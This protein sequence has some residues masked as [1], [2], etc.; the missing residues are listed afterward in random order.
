MH[1]YEFYDETIPLYF[2]ME[3]SGVWLGAALLQTRNNTNCPRDE[4]QDQQTQ[5]HCICQQIPDQSRKRY[6]NVE[7]DALGI[8]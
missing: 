2:Q 8:L 6:N 4:A 7:R 3:S 1:F 5:T